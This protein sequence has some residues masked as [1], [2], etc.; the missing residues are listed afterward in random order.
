MKRFGLTLVAVV[1]I[2]PFLLM[3]SGSLQS[4]FGIGK[5]IGSVIHIIPHGVTWQNYIDIFSLPFFPRM[6]LN[7]F[8]MIAGYIIP[9]IIVSGLVAYAFTFYDFRGKKALFL[10]AMA[11]V[12]VPTPA[13]M[14]PR[15]M[16]MK[17]L[18]LVG[19]PAVLSVQVFW[20]AGIFM[21]RAY[22]E[23]I[24]RSLVESAKMDGAGDWRTFMHIV[25]P[26]SKPILGAAIVFQGIG[27]L[28][29]YLWQSLNLVK[30]E[31]MSIIIGLYRSIYERFSRA[32]YAGAPWSDFGYQLAVSVVI[33]LPALIVF[34]FSS[35]Y[36]IGELTAGAAKE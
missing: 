25:L 33:M 8:W 32:K 10:L 2:A 31:Q 20:A 14:I 28:G 34:A 3:V 19:I 30:Y 5:L 21:F 22:F 24:P 7:S 17:T 27:S 13:I 12:F 15:Y 11:T 18:G 16:T 6:V 1:M 4:I 29:D 26:L 23:S 35:R 36:F 9:P